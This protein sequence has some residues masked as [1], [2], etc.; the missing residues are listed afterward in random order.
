MKIYMRAHSIFLTRDLFASAVTL[1]F[2]KISS[3]GRH[4]LHFSPQFFPTAASSQP[5]VSFFGNYIKDPIP[6]QIA[7]HSTKQPL[8]IQEVEQTDVKTQ[9]RK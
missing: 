8:P 9:Y 6:Q 2:P 5:V 3:F 1:W 4:R 7:K